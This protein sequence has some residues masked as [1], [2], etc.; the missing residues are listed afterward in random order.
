MSR[1]VLVASNNHHKI[2]EFRRILQG[3]VFEI[4]SPAELG[5]ALDVEETGSTFVKNARLKAKAFSAA[6]GV[7]SIADDSGLIVDA[8]DG[9]PGVYSARYGGTAASDDDRCRLV[10]SR[11]EG[12]PSELRTARFVAAISIA[13]PAGEPVD[14]EGR[15]EGLIAERPA[16]VN[17]FG[18]DPIFMYPPLGRTFAEMESVEKDRVS[19]RGQAL[20]QVAAYLQQ[21]RTVYSEDISVRT[22]TE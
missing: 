1:L 10:L 19:H 14:F 3:S 22:E 18:Y 9:E 2:E 8:L 16:G 7:S 17:G 13:D 4:L 11:L 20:R 21:Q 5:L 12:V 6:S 15:V